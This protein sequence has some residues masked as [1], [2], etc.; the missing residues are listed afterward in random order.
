MSSTR[1]LFFGT[2]DFALP[3]AAALHREGRTPIL[4]ISQPDRPVG[5]GRKLSAPPV[6][7]WARDNDLDL[8]QPESI[9]DRAFLDR[10]RELQPDVAV[11]VAYGQIFRRALLELP[12]WGCLNLH[13]SLLPAYRG[14]APIQA[15]LADGLETTGVTCMRMERGLDTGP[16]YL[17]RA[18]AIEPCEKAPELSKRLAQVGSELVLETITG[19][20]RGRLS[21]HPQGEAGV[22]YAKL[23]TKQDGVVDWTDCASRLV[24]LE[25]AYEPWPGL[26]SLLAGESVKLFGIREVSSP[27]R[28]AAPGSMLGIVAERLVVACGSGTAIGIRRLQRAGR[29][30]ILA[31]EFLRGLSSEAARRFG[32]VSG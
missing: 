29:K 4:V 30:A 25:R 17:S 24:N 6:A 13:A 23:I 31:S 22:S 10:L 8:V 11:V 1:V 15:A 27:D 7:R 16:I 32:E 21:P 18:L 14:A 26:S 28:E 9:R 20:E 12:R 3:T 2:P 5:R 19:L